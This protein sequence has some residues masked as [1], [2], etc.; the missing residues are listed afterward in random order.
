MSDVCD[1]EK[2]TKLTP[3][4]KACKA[5]TLT[6]PKGPG[7]DCRPSEQE[8]MPWL[9]GPCSPARHEDTGRDVQNLY[10]C[11]Q[12]SVVLF[13]PVGHTTYLL[14]QNTKRLFVRPNWVLVGGWNGHFFR[15]I[16][17]FC[18]SGGAEDRNR[19]EGPQ[20]RLNTLSFP[21]LAQLTILLGSGPR[22]PG[23]QVG[24]SAALLGEAFCASAVSARDTRAHP[25]AIHT[26]NKT[27]RGLHV[28]EPATVGA[29]RSV[30]LRSMQE[31]KVWVL[32]FVMRASCSCLRKPRAAS[33]AR[34]VRA[35]EASSRAWG[36]EI[37]TTKV[38]KTTVRPVMTSLTSTTPR[39]RPGPR[40]PEQQPAST[41][42]PE[43]GQP[44]RA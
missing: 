27:R 2:Q 39:Q 15:R 29:Q 24:M 38:D 44:F 40:P 4:Q 6:L 9:A 20:S 35:P 33:R 14:L 1:D 19:S 43:L 37:A 25:E 41:E 18:T 17:F 13:E 34:M 8:R 11:E 32:W 22:T 7:K 3:F 28:T 5:W 12:M 21:V 23:P 31:M 10:V 42:T 36:L 26:P 16:I 30:F